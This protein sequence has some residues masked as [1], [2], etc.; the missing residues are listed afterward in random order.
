M[1]KLNVKF[2]VVFLLA[3]AVIGGGIA[4]VL[5][6]RSDPSAK[7]LADAREAKQAADYDEAIKNYRAYLGFHRDDQ[8][9]LVE[10]AEVG[11]HCITE[12]VIQNSKQ[13][14]PSLRLMARALRNSPRRSDIRRNLAEGLI[15][16]GFLARGSDGERT[17]FAEAQK[18]VQKLRRDE[19]DPKL[20][21]M[22]AQC[23]D[24]LEKFSE[25]ISA[26][27]KLVGYQ[28]S[29]KEFNDDSATAG[30][31]IDAHV[32]L[33]NI[34]HQRG[35][36]RDDEILA[37]R[38]MDKMVERNANQADAYFQRAI[39]SKKFNRAGTFAQ[40]E[41]RKAGIVSDLETALSIDPDN[42]DVLI[43]LVDQQIRNDNT[44]VAEEYLAHARQV[45]PKDPRVYVQ[46][47]RIERSRNDGEAELATIEAGLEVI[48]TDRQ[49]ISLLLNAQLVQKQP[50]KAKKTIERMRTLNYPPEWIAF[51]EA[52][53]L[54][55]DEQW[56]EASTKLEALRPRMDIF[57]ASMTHSLDHLLGRCYKAMGQPDR[58]LDTY[59]RTLAD[60]PQSEVALAGQAEALVALKRMPEALEKLT[61]LKEVMGSESFDSDEGLRALYLATLASLSQ[62]DTQYKDRL[63]GAKQEY[64]GRDDVSDAD[65]AVVRA[66]G[67]IRRGKIK[68]A[69]DLLDKALV[70][71]PDGVRLQN[72]YL[73]ILVR[74]NGP[75]AASEYLQ[76]AT[77]R[78][79]N[80][81][82]D[83]P[84][85]LLRR[86]E[87]IVLAGGPGQAEKLKAL[88]KDVSKYEASQH[89]KLWKKMAR[90]YYHMTPRRMADAKRCLTNAAVDGLD[91]IYSIGLFELAR[92]SGNELEMQAQI[93]EAAERYGKDT[94]VPQFLQARFLLWKHMQGNQPGM[95]LVESADRLADEIARSRP[96]WQRLLELKGSIKEL[97]GEI[98]QAIDFYQESLE[99]GPLDVVTVRH[100]VELLVKDNRYA[101]AREALM[102]LNNIPQ[103]LKKEQLTLDLLTGN[104]EAALTSLNQ[105]AP[106]D[107]K[108]AEDWVRRGRVLLRLGKTGE[109]EMAFRRAVDLAPQLPQP[110]LALVEFLL[111]TQRTEEAEDE[112]REIENRL[113]QDVVAQVMG[114]CYAWLGNR[115]LAEHYLAVAISDNPRDML[116]E[117]A[118]ARYHMINNRSPLAIPH[119]NAILER[120]LNSEEK[121]PEVELWARRSLARVLAS[122][123]T[124]KLFQQ[125]LALLEANRQ[126][127]DLKSPDLNLKGLIL[128]IRPEPV[129]RQR[130]IEILEQ[131]PRDELEVEERLAL[132]QLY[133]VSDRWTECREVMQALL[134]DYPVDTR[135]LEKYI[136]MLIDKQEWRTLT[137]WMRQL[138]NR[139]P[140]K[141]Q[142]I[143]LTALSA[144]GRGKERPAVEAVQ[145]LIPEGVQ[146]ADEERVLA[147]AK[148]YEEIGLQDLAESTYRE[149]ADK[150]FEYR[151]NLAA[152]LSRQG[153]LDESFRICN[154]ILTKDRLLDICAIGIGGAVRHSTK[155]TDAEL[156]QVYKW[157]AAAKKEAP[158]SIDLITQE[159]ALL[160][161]RAATVSAA[162]SKE[163][164]QKALDLIQDVPL[165]KVNEN[166][167][168]LLANNLAYMRVKTGGDTDAALEN[169]DTAFNLLGPRIELLDTRATI[170]IEKGE[171]DRAIEDLKQA[172]LFKVDSGVYYFHLALAY[173]GKGD[174]DAAAIALQQAEDLKFTGERIDGLDREKYLKL[175]RWL[176]R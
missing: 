131:I 23:A 52:K 88:E 80:P 51:S 140:G 168:G 72:T 39:Y 28:P 69:L 32:L 25:S 67:L 79:E 150:N 70:E 106:V 159:A 4:G 94:A 139:A 100:L 65:K 82:T 116:R 15:A 141:L 151:I 144:K 118:M 142:T 171:F 126:D 99:A 107:S 41:E 102:Q 121:P 21:F 76:K 111:A 38:V 26:L 7:Y 138:Q 124:H 36:G 27:E 48:P 1:R 40:R 74:E 170:N 22:Y 156:A 169:I 17:F 45:D 136:E 13:A 89:P 122:L 60:D 58:Q 61:L 62:D 101:E 143:R 2:L 55:L 30:D 127:G 84:E 175:K 160:S 18:E 113:S 92:E 50:E 157:I 31:M 93:D 110:S 147:A 123:K 96:R 87:L 146:R 125:A 174:R 83:R 167:R 95:Q 163:N 86:V 115:M 29:K 8:D 103:A 44:Q 46:M 64:V 161:A 166:Q 68:D 3:L 85:L 105:A 98:K 33:A 81:W 53:V 78:S 37:D 148:I 133:F 130:A 75:E 56:R 91:Q 149:L 152:F 34:Y 57:P 128:A 154:A 132:G 129:Y 47:A 90:T 63:E 112:I 19:E 66:E 12:E 35:R 120:G 173:Q 165:E 73:A 10:A 176:R 153:K 9:V 49:L 11:S 155:V 43:E 158:F 114:Q 164:Y 145:Q 54:C 108:N 109:A 119:L 20:D 134:V 117:Q 5:T 172:T 14:L 59:A 77:T 137:P 162:E 97:Q 135:L 71:S 42:L 24:R 16:M 6:L 104:R